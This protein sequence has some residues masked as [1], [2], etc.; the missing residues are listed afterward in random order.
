[1]DRRAVIAA[2]AGLLAAA[3][4]VEAQQPA[5]TVQ[6]GYLPGLRDRG[7]VESK[8]INLKTPKALTLTIPPSRLQR[9]DQAIE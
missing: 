7:Y 2:T 5:K 3:I 1:M 6:I 9:A 8:N 4:A